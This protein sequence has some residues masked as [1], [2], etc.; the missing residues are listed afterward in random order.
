MKNSLTLYRFLC[1]FVA[2]VLLSSVAF[3]IPV[4]ATDTAEI[5]F[6]KKQ[7]RAGDEVIIPVTITNNPGIAAFRFRV[8]YDTDSLEFISV[9]KGNVLTSGTITNT[10]NAAEKTMTF[11]WHT[12]SNV[13]GDGTIA[14]LKFKIKNEDKEEYPLTV[15]YLAEDLLNEDL[16]QIPYIVTD[17]QIVIGDLGYSI[18]GTINSFGFENDAVT[19]RLL[20]NGAEISKI[21]S[22][23]S[24]YAFFEIQPGEYVIEISKP[25]H[26]TMTYEVMV[27]DTDVVKNLSIQLLGDLNGDGKIN[28]VDARWVL[29]AASGARELTDAQKAAADLNGDGKINA[30]DA[31]WILQVASGARVL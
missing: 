24:I 15:A 6:G 11:L 16:Q 2:L 10:T 22:T 27:T 4:Y 17:G 1:Y 12:I 19:L 13:T 29:Q 30:V 18:S 3:A 23:D 9:E 7:G 21:T 26:A 14:F 5:T 20:Q 31:R 25:H 28:A 8:S